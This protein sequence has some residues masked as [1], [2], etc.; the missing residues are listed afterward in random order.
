A[1]GEETDRQT[2]TFGMTS[3]R[4]DAATL[5]VNGQSCRIGSVVT[6]DRVQE[7][8]LL[9]AAGDSL[10][11]VR[12]HYGTE[13]LYD[14]ADRAGILLVQCVPLSPDGRLLPEVLEQV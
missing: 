1:G 6:V 13:Q 5:L 10:L 2:V 3:V 11:L 14:A 7:K 12:D 4:Q 8:Q 9:P